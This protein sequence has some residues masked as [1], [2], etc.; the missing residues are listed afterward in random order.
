MRKHKRSHFTSLHFIIALPI[1]LWSSSEPRNL[2]ANEHALALKDVAFMT[3]DLK[4]GAAVAVRL[5]NKNSPLTRLCYNKE[6]YALTDKWQIIGTDNQTASRPTFLFEDKS[7][8]WTTKKLNIEADLFAMNQ[9]AIKLRLPASVINTLNEESEFIAQDTEK[10]KQLFR[11]IS[12]IEWA[13]NWQAPLGHIHV[14]SDFASWRIPPNGVPY[15]HTGVDLRAAAGSQVHAVSD[16]VVVEANSEVI[17]GQ[18]VTIDH[19]QGVTSRYL[20]LSE[21]KVKVGDHVKAGDVIALSG[22]TG[23]AEAPHLH[24]EMRIRGV[25]VDPLSTRQLMARLSGLE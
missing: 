23:R 13:K 19:G 25:P 15:T 22:S 8:A 11:K 6:C 20:H 21:F 3:T 17:G 14:V 4:P 24:W 5:I 10:Q 9:K 2:T 1:L 12:N 7:N 16:G 18:V